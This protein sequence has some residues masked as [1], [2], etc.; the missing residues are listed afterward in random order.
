MKSNFKFAAVLLFIL[1]NALFVFGQKK[2]ITSGE[3]FSASSAAWQ[4]EQNVSRRVETVTETFSSGNTDKK[5][6]TIFESLSPDRYRHLIRKQI[7]DSVTENE[8]IRID[9]LL[10]E[11][12]TDG[13]WAKVGATETENPKKNDVNCAHCYNRQMTVEQTFLDNILVNLYE[14]FYIYRGDLGST[15]IVEKKWISDEG[16]SLKT[17]TSVRHLA[18]KVE[19]AKTVTTYEYN[20]SDLKIEAPIK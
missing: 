7:G 14:V 13:A 16:L 8:S 5:T 6:T 20:P 11:R 12:K 18:T 10:Y 17:E 3:Y 9:N 2:R 4:K 1:L 19:T 15:Y